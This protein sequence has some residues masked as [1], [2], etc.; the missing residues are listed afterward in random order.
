MNST[1][2]ARR[3]YASLTNVTQVID[4]ARSR[5]LPDRWMK[6][7]RIAELEKRSMVAVVD[8]NP[9][10]RTNRRRWESDRHI[11]CYLGCAR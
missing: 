3:A 6:T 10:P 8:S 1:E 11:G 7:S 5:N 4:R 2:E 9:F